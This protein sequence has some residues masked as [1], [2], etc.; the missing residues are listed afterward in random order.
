MAR[1]RMIDQ[2]FTRSDKLNS[3]PRDARLVYASILTV[4]DR[5]GR[6]CAE[7]LVLKVN[8][9]RKSDFTVEEIITCLAQLAGVGLIRLYAD[10]DN[11][12]ILEYT[13]FLDFNSPNNRERASDFPG[14]DD[15]EAMPLRDLELITALEAHGTSTD[16]ADA[17]AGTTTPPPTCNARATH[18]QSTRHVQGNVNG[19]LTENG[20]VERETRARDARSGAPKQPPKANK[21]KKTKPPPFNP[22]Q[23]TLPDFVSPDVWRDFTEHRRD[24]K[25]P[26]T[27][28]AATLTLKDLAKHPN[29]AD[30]MLRTSIKRGWTGVF[31]L[32]GDRR[33][34]KKPPSPELDQYRERGL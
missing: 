3:I 12:A 31:P 14:P 1:G 18:V 2:S 4:L 27:E 29:D 7:P 11:D 25:K 6:T 16:N 10:K 5:A 19:T 15:A 17:P 26:L 20:N 13:R 9:F 34:T 33:N 21:P 23:I 22:A 32:D 8:V 28:R 24:L 30:E